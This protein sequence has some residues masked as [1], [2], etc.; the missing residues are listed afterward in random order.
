[1][2]EHTWWDELQNPVLRDE[3]D[4]QHPERL[5]L[6]PKDA[7]G[8]LAGFDVVDA[9]WAPTLE[10]A[11]ALPDGAVHERVNGEWSLVETLRHLLFATDAWIT[12]VV[13]GVTGYHVLA[14]P[15]DDVPSERGAELEPVL[16]ARR[17]QHARIR[18]RLAH[19]T[20]DELNRFVTAPDAQWPPGAHRPIDCFHVVLREE[21]WHHQFAVR[22]L[23]VIAGGR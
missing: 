21:W 3:L 5:A 16:V 2:G 12:R 19:L 14:V 7:G 4:R 11:R 20:D 8:V 17:D 23:A 13:L 9:M 22:D 18:H 6:R 10:R 1:M 15:P